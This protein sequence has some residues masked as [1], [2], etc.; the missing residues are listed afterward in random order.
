MAVLSPQREALE[1]NKLVS[2]SEER[3]WW[4]KGKITEPG[5]ITTF[6]L[7]FEMPDGVLP[8]HM[9]KICVHPR[10][11]VTYMGLFQGKYNVAEFFWGGWPGR[12]K[13]P[14][15]ERLV[16]LLCTLLVD[17]RPR[18][19]GDWCPVNYGY[20]DFLSSRML[21]LSTVMVKR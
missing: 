8:E 3:D 10:V 18:A 5:V 20:L 13:T 1:R 15:A 12:P 9:P 17:I 2:V 19:V 21:P 11:G 4:L 7:S 14:E 6:E 16:S